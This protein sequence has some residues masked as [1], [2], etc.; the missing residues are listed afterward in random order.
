MTEPIMAQAQILELLS[1]LPTDV[2][3]EDLERH[4]KGHWF[5]SSIAHHL[6]PYLHQT[7]NSKHEIQNTF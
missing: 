5:E 1:R 3:A 4:R 6:T 7:L 2:A